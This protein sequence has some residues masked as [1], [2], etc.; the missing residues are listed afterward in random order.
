[1]SAQL[2]GEIQ[3][4]EDDY[5]RGE[6]EVSMTLKEL[7]NR[8]DERRNGAIGGTF[9]KLTQVLSEMRQAE[10]SIVHA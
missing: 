5:S 7:L 2:A 8:E 3:K 9:A 6:A 1:M 10:M 4:L